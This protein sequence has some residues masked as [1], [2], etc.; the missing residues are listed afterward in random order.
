MSPAE[1]RAYLE[2]AHSEIEALFAQIDRNIEA[3]RGYLERMVQ[4]AGG[5]LPLG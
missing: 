1:A 2:A 5:A 3:G 4:C